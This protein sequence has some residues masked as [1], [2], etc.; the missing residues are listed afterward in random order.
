MQAVRCRGNRFFVSHMLTTHQLQTSQLM[1]VLAASSRKSCTGKSAAKVLQAVELAAC[2]TLPQWPGAS[3]QKPAVFFLDMVCVCLLQAMQTQQMPD[4]E[5]VSNQLNPTPLS[6]INGQSQVTQIV[7][8][9]TK[10][11]PQL[12]QLTK[13]AAQQNCR[14][15]HDVDLQKHPKVRCHCLY[16]LALVW[17]VAHRQSWHICVCI[18]H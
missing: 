12:G 9:S 17:S 11:H 13:A 7:T 1:W 15:R 5:N 14:F 16:S 8:S 2:Q 10:K 4:E 3:S 18:V 6:A